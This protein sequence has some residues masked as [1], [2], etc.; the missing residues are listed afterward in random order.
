MMQRTIH[1]AIEHHQ[2]GRLAEAESI[3]LQLLR[4]NANDSDALHYLGV[5]RLSQDRAQEAQELVEISLSGRP[6]SKVNLAVAAPGDN[7]RW[8]PEASGQAIFENNT[9]EVPQGELFY[10]FPV[11]NHRNLPSNWT[12]EKVAARAIFID[13]QLHHHPKFPRKIAAMIA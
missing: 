12:K 6:F 7:R 13:Y 10:D 3:Y 1:D 11:S 5:V 4:T 8:S 9:C 2:R